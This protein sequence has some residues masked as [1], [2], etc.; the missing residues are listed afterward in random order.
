MPDGHNP[1]GLPANPVEEPVRADDHLAVGNVRK[2]WKLAARVW[3]TLQAAQATLGA[4]PEAGRRSG[5][6]ATDELE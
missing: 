3:M 4:L 1:H 6:L 5:I 2:L